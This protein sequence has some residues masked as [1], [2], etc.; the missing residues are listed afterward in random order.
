M[1]HYSGLPF[2]SGLLP[3]QCLPMVVCNVE[4][5]ECQLISL[6]GRGLIEKYR[7][8]SHLAEIIY[9]G[10]FIT[11]ISLFSFLPLIIKKIQIPTNAAGLIE[12]RC[13]PFW[14]QKYCPSHEHDNTARCCS[15]ERLE[16]INHSG[17]EYIS[18]VPIQ[19]DLLIFLLPLEVLERE[20]PLSRR[21]QALMLRVHGICYHGYW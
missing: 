14:S 9:I 6:I 5:Q 19:I 17:S 16:V 11:I 20:I 18:F 8:C 2:K 15:C 13:H 4:Y 3:D 1:K 10:F 21:W 7:S 12:Y